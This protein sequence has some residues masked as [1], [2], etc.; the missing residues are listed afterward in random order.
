[1][2]YYANFFKEINEIK[3]IARSLG[4]EVNSPDQ[5]SMV[6]GVFTSYKILAGSQRARGVP[7]DN[8]PPQNK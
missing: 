6:K 5:Y 4:R 1:M 8:P 2:N 7:V 3:E